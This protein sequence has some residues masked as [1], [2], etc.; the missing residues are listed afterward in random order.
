MTS[1]NDSMKVSSPSLY[2]I[3]C[4]SLQSPLQ[5][6][7]WVC[8]TQIRSS[9][10]LLSLPV[11]ISLLYSLSVTGQSQNSLAGALVSPFPPKPRRGLSGEL[12]L[13]A[14][15]IQCCES[16]IK[17]RGITRIS[18]FILAGANTAVEA[19]SQIFVRLKWD[20][21]DSVSQPNSIPTTN[22]VPSFV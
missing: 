17:F 10:W 1:K 22:S 20:L 4:L 3:I 16:W 21:D 13:T 12:V 11:K 2:F 7:L 15:F 5:Q 18:S 14:P 9:Q 8:N 6:F 19:E